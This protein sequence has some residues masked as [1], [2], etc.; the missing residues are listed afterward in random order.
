MQAIPLGDQRVALPR[1]GGGS[2]DSGVRKLRAHDSNQRTRRHLR[3]VLLIGRIRELALYRAE[4]L[5][6]KGFTVQ[7]PNSR[8]DDV[9]EA[10]RRG[11][12]DIVVLTY[13]LSN[14]DVLDFADLVRQHCPTCPLIVITNT[15]R[16]DTR[17]LPDAVVVADQGPEALLAALHRVSN[18]GQVQ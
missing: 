18:E 14:E 7:A 1:S 4:Y 10:I 17:V 11:G 9:L 13:T 2:G 15:E 5:R 3:K 6:G 8:R 12:F 16:P